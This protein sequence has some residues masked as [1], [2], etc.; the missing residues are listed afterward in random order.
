MYPLNAMPNSYK[1]P[2]ALQVVEF[3]KLHNRISVVLENEA[4]QSSKRAPS[5]FCVVNLDIAY[6]TTDSMYEKDI[7]KVTLEEIYRFD[8]IIKNAMANDSRHDQV[9]ICAGLEPCRQVRV[10]FL[11]GCHLIMSQGLGF[12]ET[13]LAY[14]PFKSLIADHCSDDVRL[15]EYWRGLCCAKCL[16]WI[17]FNKCQDDQSESGIQ[18]D[19]YMHYARQALQISFPVLMLAP[20]SSLD[21]H[22]FLLAATTTAPSAPS[23]RAS[24]SSAAPPA[25]PSRPAAF[26]PTQTAAGSSRPPSAPSCWPTWASESLFVSTMT[27]MVG[28]QPIL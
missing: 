10:L 9:L 16:A 21:D 14:R 13:V 5:G 4:K 1:S 22:D 3:T 19:E 24:S 8:E 17:D 23:S 27:F 25:A 12:E 7:S 2:S 18:M 26:G 28:S 6:P 11:L 20:I 15:E